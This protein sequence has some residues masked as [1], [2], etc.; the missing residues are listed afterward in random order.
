[1]EIWFNRI[2]F[3]GSKKFNNFNPFVNLTLTSS[4]EDIM[5]VPMWL[6]EEDDEKFSPIESRYLDR[7]ALR[8]RRLLDLTGFR[9]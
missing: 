9:S 8:H 4:S 3:T 1:M 7:F 5:I 6:W 2:Y